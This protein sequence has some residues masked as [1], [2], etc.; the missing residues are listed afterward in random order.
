MYF[1]YMNSVES[2]LPKVGTTIFSTMSA[3]AT[4]VGAL[5]LGQGFADYHMSDT[6]IDLTYKHMKAGA[7]QYAPMPGVMLL[8]EAIAKK[9]AHIY[10]HPLNPETEITI[11]PGATYA[12][13]FALATII[14]KGDEVIILE[15]AYD[16]YIPAIEMQGGTAVPVALQAPLFNV[17]WQAVANAVNFKT[18]AIIINTPHNPCGYCF[19]KDDWNNLYKII[20]DKNIYI[21]S[22]EVYEHIV[23][24]GAPHE[25]ILSQPLLWD[26]AFAIFSFGKVFHNTGWKIG[27]CIAPQQLTTEFRKIHQYA[28]FSV[29]TP[30]QLA[31]ADYMQDENNYLSLPSFFQ[32]KRDLFLHHLTDSKFTIHQPTAGSFFQVLGYERISTLND[33]AFAEWLTKEYKIT[34]IPLSPFYTMPYSGKFVRFCFA[35]EDDTLLKATAL[36]QQVK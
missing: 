29:N 6:L 23:L 24:D 16:C 31:L 7:N 34:A 15:P 8:R 12:I 10:N 36:L 25:S 1:S 27:Y 14:H 17:D 30:M 13:Y 3:L 35:K 19:T 32:R 5:N 28:A 21:I 20:A 11:T 18:K 26:R 22:D 9:S 2:K 33:I 4:Q